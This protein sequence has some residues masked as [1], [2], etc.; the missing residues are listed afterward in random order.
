MLAKAVK[1]MIDEVCQLDVRKKTAHFCVDN[2]V[3]LH[4]TTYRTAE[5]AQGAR[6]FIFCESGLHQQRLPIAIRLKK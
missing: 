6:Y 5:Y 1:I 3:A 4:S 2:W